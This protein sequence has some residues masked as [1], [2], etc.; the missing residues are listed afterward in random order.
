[1]GKY[2]DAMISFAS[3]PAMWPARS[4]ARSEESEPSVPTTTV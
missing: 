2:A 1:M 4:T 3:A